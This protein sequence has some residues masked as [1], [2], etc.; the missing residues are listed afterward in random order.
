MQ[1]FPFFAN[2]FKIRKQQ[3]QGRINL[4][5]HGNIIIL[6]LSY[7]IIL[8]WQSNPSPLYPV[9]HVQIKLPSVFSQAAFTSHG[10]DTHSSM[11]VK[12]KNDVIREMLTVL[13][14]SE[15]PLDP[16]F[17]YL[18]ISVKCKNIKFGI[19]CLHLNI[20]SR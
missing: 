14:N 6:I 8:P 4:S 20:G 2:D 17:F 19:K 16:L 12:N 5:F 11:S 15:Y 1:F 9:L 10:L 7:Q 13:M 18:L 3:D